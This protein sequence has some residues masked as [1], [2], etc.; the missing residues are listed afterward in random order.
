MLDFI[1]LWMPDHNYFAINNK[2]EFDHKPA[3][4]V[5]LTFQKDKKTDL[6]F[7]CIS[8]EIKLS[9]GHP[10]FWLETQSFCL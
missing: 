8:R 2:F 5:K 3:F 4:C 7:S 1:G 9:G 6:I 10:F